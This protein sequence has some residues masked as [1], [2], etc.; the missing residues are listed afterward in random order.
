MDRTLP[1]FLE[2]FIV[3]LG[4]SLILL[5]SWFLVVSTP[6]S[7]WIV[8]AANIV[9][10]PVSTPRSS[11]DAFFVSVMVEQ[12][13]SIIV[14][15]LLFAMVMK[16]RSIRLAYVAADYAREREWLPAANSFRPLHG[17]FTWVLAVSLA[18][19]LVI[20]TFLSLG[21]A[22]AIAP[23][24]LAVLRAKQ[25]FTELDYRSLL[26]LAGQYF[27]FNV[28]GLYPTLVFATTVSLYYRE[29]VRGPLLPTLE[30]QF[31]RAAA[32]S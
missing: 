7:R 12:T 14:C 22:Q 17:W 23:D 32:P 16:R 18:L 5:I 11:Y 28:Q 10:A 27:L 9:P 13:V 25:T 2:W 3:G 31:P 8:D 21:L 1:L 26:G 20:S 19:P 6:I 15:S 30:R 29:H 4:F 24:L